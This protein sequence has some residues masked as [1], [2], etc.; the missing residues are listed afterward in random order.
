MSW[1]SIASIAGQLLSGGVATTMG[2]LTSEKQIKHE[3]EVHAEN[4]QYQKDVLDYTKQ[5]N[6]LMR[7]RE[8]TAVQR[9]VED[10]KAA[11]LS[12][13]LAA[14]SA[15][16]AHQPV[17]AHPPQRGINNYM[18]RMAL[19]DLALNVLR[20]KA[21]VARTNADTQRVREETKNI[22]QDRSIKATDLD[23]RLRDYQLRE[24][25]YK[26]DKRRVDIT[27]EQLGISRLQLDLEARRVEHD[28]VRIQHDAQ[29]ILNDEQ[30][31]QIERNSFEVHKALVDYQKGLLNEQTLSERLRHFGITMDTETKIIHNK[32]EI[33]DLTLYQMLGYPTSVSLHDLDRLNVMRGQA[34]TR[35]ANSASAAIEM[36]K[37]SNLYSDYLHLMNRMR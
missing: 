35:A 6:A 23:V 16:Q 25:G 32:R 29:R 17:T 24:L 4:L 11:G 1:A 9:R 33:Y 10:L 3:Q 28:G 37:S 26:L 5:Q 20:Q 18:N 36:L 34:S 19:A 12:P 31:I 7:E 14:G 2:Y 27:A 13:T 30:R 15:A 8:D 22:I 21:D